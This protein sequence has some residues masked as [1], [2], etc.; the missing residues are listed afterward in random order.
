MTRSRNPA[1][2]RLSAVLNREVPI[3]LVLGAIAWLAPGTASRIAGWTMVAILILTPV[4]RVG[5]LAARWMDFDRRFAW[6]GWAL[7]AV[8]TGAAL[9]AVL[10]R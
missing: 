8:V 5:W 1:R 9:V 3:V 4:G 2:R 6:T 7:L 10:V